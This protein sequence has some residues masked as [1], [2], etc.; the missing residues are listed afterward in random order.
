MTTEN[1]RTKGI[2]SF[3]VILI[4]VPI[5]I[6]ACGIVVKWTNDSQDAQQA[7]YRRDQD[8]RQAQ[9][10]RQLEAKFQQALSISSS[11]NSFSI[12]TSVC[13][14]RGFLAGTVDDT[15]IPV[16]RRKE[17]AK[18]LSTQVTSPPGFKCETLPKKPPKSG[19]K[20]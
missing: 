14:F 6:F 3:W 12:N 8:H 7:A 4:V 2:S 10:R 17:I 9:Y 18:F 20:P 11:Q 19:R 1:A 5:V 16:A 15:R 13:G